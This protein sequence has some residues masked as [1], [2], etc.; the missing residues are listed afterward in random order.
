M[1]SYSNNIK[2]DP[3]FPPGRF[4]H[5]IASA[6]TEYS[7]LFEAEEGYKTIKESWK[8]GE[9]LSRAAKTA[10]AATE[11]ASSQ[12]SEELNTQTT[13]ASWTGWALE[14][15]GL[16]NSTTTP[17]SSNGIAETM[18]AAARK[19]RWKGKSSQMREKG[20]LA[21]SIE[22]QLVGESSS[23]DDGDN[24]VDDDD[25]NILKTDLPSPRMRRNLPP[26]VLLVVKRGQCWFHEK[27]I[28]AQEAFLDFFFLLC[29][30]N[31]P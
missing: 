30:F 9:S 6:Q 16:A 24:K 14:T 17:A 29:V 11:A 1:K 3:S 15:L 26:K 4:D 2:N 23:A 21:E 10:V 7:D 27:A 22:A 31:K 5:T 18:A 25:D 28:K 8:S 19:R 12:Q 20:Q 13:G